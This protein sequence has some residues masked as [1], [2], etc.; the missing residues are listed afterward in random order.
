MVDV[1][2]RYVPDARL[3]V[4]HA[5]LRCVDAPGIQASRVTSLPV[6]LR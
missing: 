5:Q 6:R 3:A 1:L 4:P 2:R